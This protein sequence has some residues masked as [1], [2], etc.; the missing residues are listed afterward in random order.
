ML[1]GGVLNI[2]DMM[3]RSLACLFFLVNDEIINDFNHL[4]T[5]R[6]IGN[7]VAP[8]TQMVK[9]ITNNDDENNNG[10]DVKLHNGRVAHHIL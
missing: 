10:N 3:R 5:T 1:A 6:I 7:V 8:I 4:L 9:V 2:S